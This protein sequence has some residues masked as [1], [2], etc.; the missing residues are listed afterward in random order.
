MSNS[1][2]AL[3]ANYTDLFGPDML[4]VLEEIFRFEL[5]QHQSV[6]DQLMKTVMT[7]R[8]IW[9]STELHDMPLHSVVAEGTEY[10]YTRPKQGASKTLVPVKYGLGF[11]ISEEAIEDGKF[12]HVSDALAKMARSAK[13]SQEIDAINILN[14]GFTTETTADGVVL[15]SASHTLPSGG[16]FRNKL[17]TDADLSTTSLRQ[18]I[19]D[20]ETQFVGDSGIIYSV[21][22]Q[23]LVVPSNLRAYAQELIGSSLKADTAENN[24]NSLGQEGLRVISSPHLSDTDAWFLTATPSE[25]GL[26]IVSRKGIETSSDADFDTD[27]IRYKSRYREK[28][29]VTHAIGVMG[30][31][32]AS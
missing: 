24:M 11:S 31:T 12:D 13:E 10:S 5:A 30:T 14:N 15:F 25:T 3:R 19:T 27:S 28:L 2:A 7:D 8:D 21:R 17:S 20:F 22:P 6:R 23:N 29:G 9:Q 18:M 26:R 16:T 32:G 1:P 4:P